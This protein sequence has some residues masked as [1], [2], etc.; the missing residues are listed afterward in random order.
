MQSAQCRHEFVM[1]CK[2][3]GGPQAGS[4]ARRPSA[5]VDGR[6]PRPAQSARYRGGPPTAIPERKCLL[7]EG[8][9]RSIMTDPGAAVDGGV[10]LEKRIR[11]D[12]YVGRAGPG[13]DESRS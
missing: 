4:F 8:P 2:V 13:T 12:R 1:A 5:I 3:D 6:A 11:D 10:A 7:T 9:S